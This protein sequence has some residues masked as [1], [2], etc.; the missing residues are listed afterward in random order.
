MLN[1]PVYQ[2]S[3]VQSHPVQ[4]HP[5]QSHVVETG[6]IGPIGPPGPPGQSAYDIWLANGNTGTLTDFFEYLRGPPANVAEI[7]KQ[8]SGQFAP[9]ENVNA[10]V[11]TDNVPLIRALIQL[12]AEIDLP[13][14]G[15]TSEAI[16]LVRAAATE[17]AAFT[18]YRAKSS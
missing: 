9:V 8:L 5:V 3:P 15:V 2:G 16:P 17:V 13:G 10:L 4:S 11:I 18:P 12:K 6:P 7:T 14:V 1:A